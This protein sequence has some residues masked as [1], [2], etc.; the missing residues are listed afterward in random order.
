MSEQKNPWFKFY[1]ADWRADQSL[2]LCSAAAR[3][4][5]VE[6]MCLMHEAKP[7]GHLLVNGK[8][9]TDAQLAI[10]TGIP[11][12]QITALIGELDNAGVFSRNSDGVIY[13]RKMTRSAKRAAINKK[14]G[15]SGGNP[16]LVNRTDNPSDKPP[17]ALE[18]RGQSLD[19]QEPK[20][21][22]SSQDLVRSLS[23]TLK[24]Q[25]DWTPQQRKAAWLSNIC[26]ELERTLTAEKYT[27]WLVAYGEGDKTAIQI[28]EQ[29]DQRLKREKERMAS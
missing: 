25:K 18:A 20:K 29:T 22:G 23:R 9:V 6:C 16:S 26:R 14:N 5:W 8:S 19:K 3:G 7:Y 15:K 27:A 24:N 12:D 4:L 1:P 13:S 17:L 28:A 2:R 21:E 10:Q 11:Q